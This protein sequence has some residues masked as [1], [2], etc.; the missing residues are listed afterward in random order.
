MV[1]IK[2]SPWHH[3]NTLLLGDSAH[4]IVPFFG[5]GLN[6]AFEDCTIFLELLDR[7]GPDWSSLF[8]EFEQAR[9]VNTDSI[10]DL[11]VENFVEMR[12]RVADPHFLFGK[13]VELALQAKF[14]RNFVP[15]Y[16]MVTFHRIPY[17]VAETRGKI[18]DRML[19][20]LCDSIDRI[21]DIDWKKAE[22]LIHRDLTPLG[23]L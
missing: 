13:K 14:P 21:E 6:C 10:A 2:C 18:Q 12:D 22:T 1:T 20:E 4:A 9:K 23:N 11:A 3:E 5:Q 16:A 8:S 7:L 15:K 17:S 19:A